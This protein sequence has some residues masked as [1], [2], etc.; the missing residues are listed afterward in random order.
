MLSYPPLLQYPSTVEVLILLSSDPTKS[1]ESDDNPSTFS[2]AHCLP[3][4][5]SSLPLPHHPSP[6][7]LS[8]KALILLSSVHLIVCLPLAFLSSLLSYQCPQRWRCSSRLEVLIPLS[9]A[10]PTKTEETD[11]APST[12]WITNPNNNFIGNVAAGSENSGWVAD[13]SLTNLTIFW[14]TIFWITIFWITIFWITIFWITIFWITIFW[15]TIF[16]ITIFW[17]AI[18]PN[19]SPFG[20]YDAAAS[21]NSGWG[22][23]E[24]VQ[25]KCDCERGGTGGTDRSIDWYR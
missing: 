9:A 19:N 12:F 11:D 16:W 13:W 10:D 21:E 18:H 20:G 23:C 17:I 8:V 25:C 2:C 1:E 7:F 6:P 15:I 3:Y 4:S 5:L 22:G 14:I 24:S